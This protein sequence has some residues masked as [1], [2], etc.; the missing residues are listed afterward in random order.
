MFIPC[1]AIYP[2]DKNWYRGRITAIR[3]NR[4]EVRVAFVDYGDFEFV[5]Y[6]DVRF[7]HHDFTWLPVQ[8]VNAR[9]AGVKESPEKS[10]MDTRQYLTDL[11]ILEPNISATILGAND[12]LLSLELYQDEKVFL[13]KVI[14]QN[15]HG[16]AF[17]EQN[18][19]EVN[20]CDANSN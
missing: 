2:V 18:D 8:A 7:L 14:L 13:N 20:T 17:D 12:G 15:G 10:Q 3:P 5:K 16:E 9:L 1:A 4:R 11:L 19:P 6:E